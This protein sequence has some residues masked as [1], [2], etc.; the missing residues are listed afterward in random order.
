MRVKIARVVGA[1]VIGTTLFA[2]VSG[3]AAHAGYNCV[4]MSVQT[5]AVCVGTGGGEVFAEVFPNDHAVVGVAAGHADTQAALFT[6]SA[7][8]GAAV[9]CDHHTYHLV[10]AIGQTIKRIDL[11]Q[12][13]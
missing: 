4:P 1:L 8:Y 7:V 13:C 12:H 6:N 10:Y 11:N 2:G 5:P 9:Y 3:G